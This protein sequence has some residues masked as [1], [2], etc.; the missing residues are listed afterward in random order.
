ML[1]GLLICTML[2]VVMQSGHFQ[3][4][5]SPFLTLPIYPA[6]SARAGI[7]GDFT[8]RVEIEDGQAKKVNITQ[9]VTRSSRDGKDEG[10]TEFCGE[11]KQAITSALAHWQFLF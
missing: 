6:L 10:C 1:T 11:M 9:G 5:T 8:V 2:S 4:D 3:P 7:E